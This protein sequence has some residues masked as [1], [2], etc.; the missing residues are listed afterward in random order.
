MGL[1][2]LIYYTRLL[3]RTIVTCLRE[4][5]KNN[6]KNSTTEKCGLD[7]ILLKWEETNA[8][9]NSVH[10]S[11]YL[12]RERTWWLKKNVCQK[13]LNNQKKVYT[14]SLRKLKKKKRKK[15]VAEDGFDPSTSGLWAQHAP[16]APLCCLNNKREFKR[17]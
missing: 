10:F 13:I 8:L 3:H 15:K 6:V 1:F 7:S 17:I 11:K 12:E 5:F 2:V 14:K 9:K 4:Y 16:T